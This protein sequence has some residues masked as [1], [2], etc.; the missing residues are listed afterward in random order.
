MIEALEPV[1]LEHRPLLWVAGHDHGLQVLRGETARYLVLSGAGILGHTTQPARLDSTL[2]A[3]GE[4]GFVRL[5]LEDGVRFLTVVTVDPQ[6]RPTERF[7]T[8]LDLGQEVPPP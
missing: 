2:F 8:R 1:L 5:D 4:A 6:G 3:S 7:T